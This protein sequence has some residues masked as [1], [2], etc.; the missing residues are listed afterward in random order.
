MTWDPVSDAW[1][2][3]FIDGEGCFK[4]VRTGGALRPGALVPCF[5]I[6]M[7]ADEAPVIMQ[8]RGAFGGGVTFRESRGGAKPT[9]HWA[10]ASKADLRGLCSY[11]DAFPL[12]A[13]KATDY[14]VWRE[15]VRVYARGGARDQRL[16]ALREALIAGRGYVEP[17]ER[18]A[19]PLK[20][21]AAC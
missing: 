10:V 7:R 8:L 4:I 13:K 3:G 11:L 20:V 18:S 17:A 12:R 1:A 21:V 6:G 19:A 5:E 2:A 16:P 14:A 15:A 9:V